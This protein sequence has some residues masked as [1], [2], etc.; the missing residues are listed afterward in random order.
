MGPI[1]LGQRPHWI[2][3]GGLATRL[4]ELGARLAGELWS[5]RVLLDAP[6]LVERVHR[7]Y[8]D[9]GADLICTATY[10]A[11][12]PGLVRC[13]LNEAQA[14]E[15]IASAVELARRAV[16]A[17]PRARTEHP[18]LVV[19]SVGP[20]GAYLAD[21][22]E[23][24][25]EYALGEHGLYLFHR[26][27]VRI[28]RDAGARLFAFETVPS[29]CEALALLRVLDDTEGIRAWISCQCRDA[30]TL[31]DGTPLRDLIPRLSHP[32]LLAVG[33]N[34]VPPAD[35]TPL[36]RTFAEHTALPLVAYPNSGERYADGVWRGDRVEWWRSAP[37]WRRLGARI[38][39]GC[40]RTGPSDLERL[41][42]M[43]S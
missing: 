29:A 10:Q 40:C 43:L 14:R 15:L 11:T 41:R 1:D 35:V 22:S 16:A 4:E 8:L 17:H 2:L 3:D 36:L 32:R 18:P 38:L 23:Y 12:L 27:R 42:A 21:G 7:E 37:E 25:G 34:C 33:C 6:E 24:R 13:G 39:G 31:A 30:R 9:A 19:A 26:P 28:L 20:F 5:A